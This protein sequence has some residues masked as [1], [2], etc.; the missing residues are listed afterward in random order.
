MILLS[1]NNQL[2]NKLNLGLSEFTEYKINM[3]NKDTSVAM[4][5]SFYRMGVE[6]FIDRPFSGW[7][8]LS[9]IGA[10]NEDKF[11]F[12]ASKET[13]ESPRHGFHNEI[14]TNS[15]RS[16]I[17]GLIAV[18]SL[19]VVIFKKSFEGL[20]MQLGLKHRLVSIFI[21]VSIVHI[22]LAGLTTENTNLTFLSAFI[23]L[24]FSVLLGELK[25]LEENPL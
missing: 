9:W 14:I 15:V 8:D 21:M 2:I 16:G 18:L 10:M 12:F 17:W 13:F 7:G 23:G 6:Y 24:T 3:L 25:F 5:L 11:R 4:R 19:Y 20:K 22:F 1:L